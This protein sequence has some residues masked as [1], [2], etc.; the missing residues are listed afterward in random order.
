MMVVRCQTI[1]YKKKI[2]EH[3][4]SNARSNVRL[5]IQLHGLKINSIE[6]T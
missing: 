4:W 5:L 2:I 3:P 1:K 6:V